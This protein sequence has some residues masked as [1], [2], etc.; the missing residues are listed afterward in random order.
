MSTAGYR[1]VEPVEITA[2]PDQPKLLNTMLQYHLKNL[3]YTLA[4]LAQ[5]LHVLPEELTRLYSLDNQP[6]LP[7]IYRTLPLA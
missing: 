1:K 4:D 6:G 3:S 7:L 2:D 5:A